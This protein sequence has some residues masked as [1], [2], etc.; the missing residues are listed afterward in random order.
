[1][2]RLQPK[3]KEMREKYKNDP[4]RVQK[5]MMKLYKEEKV[6]PMGGCLPVLLQMPLLY[7]LF[8]V[9][10]ATIQFRNAP[11]VL[12]IKDLSQP[13]IIF[14]LPMTL[15]LYGSHV[16]LLPILMGVSTFFQ[17]KSSMT[18]P[19]QKMMLY[20][21]PI[22]MTLIFNNFP[23]GL[24]LYYTLFNVLTMIQQKL[25]PPPQAQLAVEKK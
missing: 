12:W 17:S 7:G 25:T 15:P 11:F 20:F 16:A 21:M 5:E 4:Q 6:N 24:T 3:I 2:Q 8:I 23:S 9:F 22:F 18:D 19:N 1:M 10:R 14:Q 13:D